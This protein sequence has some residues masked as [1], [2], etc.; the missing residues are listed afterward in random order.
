MS[1]TSKPGAPRVAVWMLER[2]LPESAREVVLG[3][4]EEELA[5]RVCRERGKLG[6][7]LWFW[8]HAVSSLQATR[9]LRSTAESSKSRKGDGP[10][11][12]WIQDLR[13]GLRLLAR[14]PGFAVAAV[15]TLALGIGANATM[16]TLMEASLLR[17]LP[18][19]EPDQLVMVGQRGESG[20][21]GNVGYATYEDWRDRI[22]SFEELAALRTWNPTLVS[23]AVKRGAGQGVGQEAGQ[24]I[25]AEA[26]AEGAARLPGMR[27][28]WNYFELLGV[29]PSLGRSFLASEDRPGSNHVVVLTDEAWT[30]RFARDPG[31]IGSTLDLNGLDYR[32]VGILPRDFEPLI[33]EWYHERAEIYG[34]L[35]YDQTLSW[36]CRD[37]QHLKA[38]GR[39]RPDVAE[40]AALAELEQVQSQMRQEHPS[41][42]SQEPAGFDSLSEVLLGA[43]RPLMRVLLLAVGFV[44]LISC[45][46]VAHLMIARTSHRRGELSVRSALGASKARLRAQLMAES[47]LVAVM[48][49]ALGLALASAGLAV[50]RSGRLPFDLPRI[51]QATL[52]PAIAMA[53]LL[54]ALGVTL[55]LGLVS[56]VSLSGTGAAGGAGAAWKAGSSVAG[57]GTR[58]MR[59]TLVA[60]DVALAVCLLVASALMLRSAYGLLTVDTG[61]DRD[62]V[63]AANLSLVGPS[64]RDDADVLAFIEALEQRVQALPGVEE[65]ALASQIP[66]GGNYDS[67]GLEIEG[68]VLDNHADAPSPQRY[69]VTP[70]YFR[71]LRIP[72]LSGRLLDER[73]RA[74]AELAMVINETTANKLWPG[75]VALGQRVKIGGGDT[76]WRTIVGVVGDVRHFGLG[77]AAP[78]QMYLP[79]A[80][81]TDSYLVLVVRSGLDPRAL[82]PSLRSAVASLAPDVPLYGVSTLEQLA[83][84][85]A[86]RTRWTAFLLTAFAAVALL[87]TA[88]GIHGLVAFWVARRTREVGIRVA[89]GAERGD[90]LRLVLRQGLGPIV[91]G[92]ALGLAASLLVGRLLGSLLFG[93]S[94][95]DPVAYALVLPALL[96]IGAIAVL[97]PSR[98]ALRISPTRALRYE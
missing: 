9:E 46:N 71:T 69:G 51:D 48:G 22:T 56:S 87:M 36:A 82:V 85:S 18:F 37:C 79:E 6:A 50:L 7:W 90:V 72:L 83:L 61:F 8:R 73:D 42:Y 3:D 52:S 34:A 19:E 4:L 2:W 15:L 95:V 31:V 33:S 54:L 68:R 67:W 75:E 63:V 93:V 35:G 58:K 30:R 11:M 1:E 12:A 14:S 26:T 10:V 76:P 89:L 43:S 16:L 27:V 49:V 57:R 66:L 74:D 94:P 92:A 23:R 40:E 38:V 98:R 44:L 41:E 53:A 25:A 60:A 39:L 91:L 70:G 65:A 80:Q 64:W 96:L 97:V 77:D 5:N 59:S 45:A 28:T 29:E 17:P 84:G 81:L 24:Q 47:G 78:M 21:V 88:I 32:V 86:A 20:R 62:N 55:T 13:F